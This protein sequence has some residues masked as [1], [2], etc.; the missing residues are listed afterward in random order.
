VTTRPVR[1]LAAAALLAAAGPASASDKVVYDVRAAVDVPVIVAGFAIAGLPYLWPGRIEHRCPCDPAE[2]NRLDRFA[3]DLHSQTAQVAS[4]VTVGLA[5]GVP[6]LVDA[7]RLGFGPA[8]TADA[9]VYT[10]TLA[11]NSALV[12]GAKYAFQRPR[13]RT[14]AGDPAFLTSD[15]GYQSFYSGHTSTA[16]AALTAAAWTARWRHG[17]QVWP[18]VVVGVVGAG[19]GAERVLAGRHFPTDVIVGAA[20][21]FA[22]GTAVPWLHRKHDDPAVAVS[23]LPYG[24]SFSGRF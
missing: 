15:D 19:V 20:M 10:E 6:L 22:V 17:E 21:G 18:W 12:V 11:V 7:L 8:L 24:V 9:V 1:A 13:P 23:P 5:V 16:V 2:V 4:D 3:V 14:Y